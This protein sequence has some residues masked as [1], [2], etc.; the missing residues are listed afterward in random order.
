MKARSLFTIST[1]IAGFPAGILANNPEPK[2]SDCHVWVTDTSLDVVGYG[3]AVTG[4]EALVQVHQGPE[5]GKEWRFATSADHT[6]QNHCIAQLSSGQ[7]DF[8]PGWKVKTI[9]TDP[10]LTLT[11]KYNPVPFK[12]Y[13]RDPKTRVGPHKYFVVPDKKTGFSNEM[14]Y[15][16]ESLRTKSGRQ[17]P[18][19][20]TNDI[21]QTKERRV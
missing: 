4:Q 12:G 9:K 2:D 15:P 17:S 21:A 8:P 7:N 19:H 16:V 13:S 6:Q 20:N 10:W 5:E 1:A 14:H 18:G 3:K 11:H